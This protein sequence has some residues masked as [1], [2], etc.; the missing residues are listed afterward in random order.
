M[1][2]CFLFLEFREAEPV[3]CCPGLSHTI[4]ISLLHLVYLLG[5]TCP[6][7]QFSPFHHSF[8]F[9]CLFYFLWIFL[10]CEFCIDL[11]FV[12][13]FKGGTN[14]RNRYG[15]V[16]VA[17]LILAFSRRHTYSLLVFS[18]KFNSKVPVG[19]M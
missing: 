13:V 14:D 6:Q 9:A 18:I 3:G 1:S 16:L 4:Y 5:R 10:I 15:G 17:V 11:Y 2:Q 7:F 12:L 8:L 19:V